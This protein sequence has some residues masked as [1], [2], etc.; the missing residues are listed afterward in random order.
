M[1]EADCGIVPVVDREGKCIGVITDRD[2]C[3]AAATKGR[4]A[5]DIKVSEVV[6][7]KCHSCT[8]DAD[9]R[10]ALRIMRTQQVRR[11]PVVDAKGTLQGV[12]SMN[13]LVLRARENSKGKA[14]D[15]AYEDVMIALKAI[16]TH[17]TE[18]KERVP[19]ERVVVSLKA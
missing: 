7:G 15:L 9:V 18:A 14:V 5:A 16:C 2:I 11:L 6:S 13:D 4:P 8:P 3:I 19:R 12:I 1:W 10:D 17:R